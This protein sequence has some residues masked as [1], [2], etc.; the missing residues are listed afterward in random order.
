MLTYT[1]HPLVD[2][3]I[4][5][6]CAFA[7]KPDPTLLTQLD[8]DAISEYM[9]KNYVVNPLKSFLTVA[10]PNSGFTQPA[11]EKQPEKRDIYAQKV[12]QA[13]K[14]SCLGSSE[15]CVFTGKPAAALSFD[16]NGNLPPG[17]VF[18]QHI[19]L[20]TGEGCINFHPYGDAGIPISGEALLAIQALPLGCA[21]VNGRLLA[22]HSN[23]PNTIYHFARRFLSWNRK[24]VHTSRLAGE[25][26]LP[27]LPKRALT[28]IIDLLLQIQ[29]EQQMLDEDNRPI[30]LTAYHL[31]NS[32][33]GVDLNIYHLPLE[34]TE[35]LK[36]AMTPRYLSQWNALRSRG[37]EIVQSKNSK[38]TQKADG[39]QEPRYNVLYEDLF[40]LPVDA[41]LF[42]RRYFL[43]KPERRFRQGD[44]RATYSVRDDTHLISWDLTELFIRKVVHMNE[45]RIQH[46]RQIG[47]ILA[48]YIS[49]ENDRRF[50]H[51][52]LTARRYDDLRAALIRVSVGRLKRGQSPLITFEPYIEAFEQGEDLP[53]SDWRLARDLVL[54][55]MI[56]RLY[57]LGWIQANKD[58]LPEPEI[59]E[60]LSV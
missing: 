31:S 45:S 7:E 49:S 36:V 51:T 39:I 11:F 24:V 22:V 19:P 57:Q 9:S 33:Q 37:W 59:V 27:E 38:K 52:F 55:R 58:E 6:I 20:L 14:Y 30:S 17:R 5:T 42:I 10:F 15:T 28:L 2:V 35:F 18:R 26:K 16:V 47:D 40:R 21:K 34:I 13:Y 23:D 56:E 50:F 46:L 1:G 25:K 29:E 32:G 4:A 41:A 53:Y 43:R 60:E 54:I 48:E 8:L 44:P 12:L 3:G